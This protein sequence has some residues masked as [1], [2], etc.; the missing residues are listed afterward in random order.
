MNNYWLKVGILIVKLQLQKGY[1]SQN[2][3]ETEQNP[4]AQHPLDSHIGHYRKKKK[5]DGSK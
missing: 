2:K 5:E 3:D 1:T 4:S